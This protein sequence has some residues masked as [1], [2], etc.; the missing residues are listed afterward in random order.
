MPDVDTGYFDSAFDKREKV[1]GKALSILKHCKDDFDVI[2]CRGYSGMMI[3]PTLAFCLKKKLFIVRKSNEKSHSA[4]TYIG[5]L[6]PRYLMVDDFISSGETFNEIK[7]ALEK[8]HD[9]KNLPEPNIVAIY[10][11]ESYNNDAEYRGI[12]LWSESLSYD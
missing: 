10:L 2:V 1:I 6:G 11:Y 7:Q 12:P 8:A 9:K 4:K 5:D 3:A